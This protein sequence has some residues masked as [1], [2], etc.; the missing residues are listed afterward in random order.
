[1]SQFVQV[2][3]KE[4][5]YHEQFYAETELFEAGSWLARPVK[6][7]MDTLKLLDM[8]NISVLDLGCGVGRNSIPIA[9]EVKNNNGTVT[10][11]DLIPSAIDL[12]HKNALKY[13]VEDIIVAE[14]ADVEKYD[15]PT[16]KYDYIVACSC[17]EHVS[18]EEAFLS[19]LKQ[20][21]TGTKNNGIHCILMSTDVKEIEVHSGLEHQGLIEL[22]LMTEHAFS[23][24]R[25]TYHDW[26]IMKEHQV[27]QEVVENI[28][29]TE[30]IYRSQWI[31]FV[32]IKQF[33]VS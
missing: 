8:A 22:N 16:D 13:E 33:Q 15:I 5:L 25:D 17:L 1:M 14:V 9:Q 26:N 28:N 11:V 24:L 21:Q 27:Q 20:M 4:I 2:R 19:Q 3:S 32:A 10:C 29:G 23:L 6:I 31:T 12:L 7:V 18:S 30:I